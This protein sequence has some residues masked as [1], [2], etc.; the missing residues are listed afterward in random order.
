MNDEVCPAWRSL[1]GRDDCIQSQGAIARAT[2]AALLALVMAMATVAVA[3]VSVL[4]PFLIGDLGITRSQIG[5]VS[6]AVGFAGAL[7]SLVFGPYTDRVG[8]LRVA[9]GILVSGFLVLCL[10]ASAPGP[11]LILA[12][13]I[14]CGIANGASNPAT[15]T[16]ISRHYPPAS[17][18]VVMGIKQS[19]VPAGL[20]LTGLTLP[21][22]ALAV[23]WRVAL[24]ATAA[25]PLVGLIWLIRLVPADPAVMPRRNPSIHGHPT[26]TITG[27]TPKRASRFV[28]RLAL[29]GF[30]MGAGGGGLMSFLPLF[31]VEG[32]GLS[33][34]EA[35]VAGAGLG[36]FGIL[37]RIFWARS[38]EGSAD[39]F[40]PL[41]RLAAISVVG[42]SSI[43]AA[44]AQ[45]TWALW[46]GVALAGMAVPAWNAV[47]MLAIVDSEPAECVGRSSG[48]VSCAFLLGMSLAPVPFGALVD[49]TG[50][51]AYGWLLAI[52]ALVTAL[53]VCIDYPGRRSHVHVDGAS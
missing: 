43:M 45:M 32:V 22:M 29:Y 49:A 17:R 8:G 11:Y 39:Y 2:L 12:A 35:G 18:G 19:G 9:A 44:N 10:I 42:T 15:N 36:L 41:R 53:I 51:Y 33:V 1:V 5:A 50:S 3:V 16:L 30:A 23:G 20:F 13:A 38:S 34:A 40:V 25:I 52:A 48:I 26:E 46:V 21:A 14:I 27:S 7:T 28:R 24:L 37:G 47:G 6:T 4:A 31:A